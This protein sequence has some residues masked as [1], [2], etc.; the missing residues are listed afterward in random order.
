LR[1]HKVDYGKG[2][3]NWDAIIE[4]GRNAQK[5]MSM[6]PHALVNYALRT[7]FGFFFSFL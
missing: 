4:G 2:T 6:L 1:D 7:E 3:Y 5:P